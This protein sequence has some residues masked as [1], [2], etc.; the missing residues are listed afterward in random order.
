MEEKQ[1]TPRTDKQTALDNYRDM[2]VYYYN[3]IGEKSKHTGVLITP[4]IIQTLTIRYLELGGKLPLEE[5]E[6]DWEDYQ[7][8]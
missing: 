8:V 5:N 6:T 1:N 2:L 4:R 3:N 7:E